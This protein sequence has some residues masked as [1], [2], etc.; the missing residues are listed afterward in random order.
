[1]FD[2]DFLLKIIHIY[3]LKTC[4]GNYEINIFAFYYRKTRLWIV[5]ILLLRYTLV[6]QI[7]SLTAFCTLSV[8]EYIRVHHG[9][10]NETIVIS[11]T[12]ASITN[13]LSNKRTAPMIWRIDGR[14]VNSNNV[15]GG[16][17][18]SL[19][20]TCWNMTTIWVR[21]SSKAKYINLGTWNTARE[22]ERNIWK[23]KN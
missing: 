19:P 20:H 2:T 14:S 6:F 5:D 7:L 23:K 3:T 13:G 11:V 4:H 17:Y 21:T 9:F 18:E 15:R 10:K 22:P 1:M 8:A 16:R 12:V